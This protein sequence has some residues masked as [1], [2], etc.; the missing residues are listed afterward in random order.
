MPALPGA[1]PGALPGCLDRSPDAIFDDG[2]FE[3]NLLPPIARWM[4]Q[5]GR[6]NFHAS[7]VSEI[8]LDLT[9]HLPD[10]AARPLGL[11]ILLNG[12]RLCACSL[13]RYGWLELRILVPE[14]LAG[15]ETSNEFE[16]ELRADRTWQPRPNEGETRDDRELSV[17]VCNLVIHRDAK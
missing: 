14:A 6:V 11:E 10:L 17:A 13:R 15:S 16:L 8:R 12:E 7:N 2:W 3:P 9:T 4:G 5:R 1:F